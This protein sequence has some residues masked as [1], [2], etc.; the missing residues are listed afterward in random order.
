[1][2]R[3]MSYK[4]EISFKNNIFE[5]ESIS[6]DC[7]YEESGRN[8]SGEFI[9]SG[10]Y[11]PCDLDNIEDFSYSLPFE[12]SIDNVVP[13]SLEIEISDFTY[14]VDNNK[15]TIF[16]DYILKY[17]EEKEEL[18]EEEFRNFLNEHEVDIVNLKE[19]TENIVEETNEE[20]KNIENN[21]ETT[22]INNISSDER[23]ITYNIHIV[24]ETDTLESISKKYD[25]TIE[26]IKSFNDIEDIK[27]GMKVIV[28]IKDE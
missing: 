25:I 20:R 24:N 2:K 7:N 19:E 9:V 26:E 27:Y 28:P 10:S 8:A 5:V 13:D 3:R 21:I 22:I 23:Y 12:E 1:M 14:E 17:E 6:L 11:K 18:N 16:I 4:K 15:L